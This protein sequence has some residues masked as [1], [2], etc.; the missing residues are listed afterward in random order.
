MSNKNITDIFELI[1]IKELTPLTR[2]NNATI[3]LPYITRVFLNIHVYCI[4]IV[5]VSDIYNFS[6][7]L[8]V[9]NTSLYQSSTTSISFEKTLESNYKSHKKVICSI[10][11]SLNYHT[12]SNSY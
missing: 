9:T 3:K 4:P 1:S 7:K 12:S 11:V 8:Y 6:R 10:E 5:N 2:K